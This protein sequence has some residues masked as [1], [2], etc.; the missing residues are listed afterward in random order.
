M[1]AFAADENFNNDILRGLL[2]GRPDLDILRVQDVGLSDAEDP[3][4]LFPTRSL[5]LRGPLCRITEKPRW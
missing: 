1:L 5:V 4:I 2:R 3:S